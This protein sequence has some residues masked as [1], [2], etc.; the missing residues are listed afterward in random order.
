MTQREFELWGSYR[1]KYGPLNPVRMYD[2]G[3]AV[4]ASQVNN[5]GGGKAKPSDFMPY[6]KEVE[7]EV[8]QEDFLAALMKTGRARMGNRKK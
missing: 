3:S 7:E 6:G 5:S 4:I 1:S 8:D 2:Q